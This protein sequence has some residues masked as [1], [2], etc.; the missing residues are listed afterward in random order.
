MLDIK[1]WL[2]SLQN[3]LVEKVNIFFTKKYLTE[4]YVHVNLVK[5]TTKGKPK[6]WKR[7]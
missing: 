6:F 7:M 1:K 4:K 5:Q 2:K 3:V